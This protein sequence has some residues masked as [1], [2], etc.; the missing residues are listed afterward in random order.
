MQYSYWRAIPTGLMLW[1]LLAPLPGQ[2]RLTVRAGFDRLP[3]RSTVEWME[4]EAGEIF[5]DAGVPFSWHLGPE[6]VVEATGP[7]VSVQFHGK[8]GLEPGA[9]P[10]PVRGPMAWV[11]PQ[12]GEIRSFIDVD[13]DRTAAMIWQNRGTL[14]LPLVTRTFGRALA[15]VV[16]HELYHYLT[17]SAFHTG[18]DL[19]RPAMTSMDLT[20]PQVRFECGEIEA[21]RKG[22]S[23]FT[24]TAQPV[25]RTPGMD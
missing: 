12:G 4:Q 9:M 25:G 7:Q 11:Q 23:K 10:A 18:S 8:C 24:G 3:D 14:P 22:M 2:T 20:M 1:T 5:S 13:C 16:A 6:D 17:Q 15:R 19:F 21:L